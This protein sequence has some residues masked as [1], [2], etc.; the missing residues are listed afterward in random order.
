MIANGRLELEPPMILLLPPCPYWHTPSEAQAS[1]RAV[2]KLATSL[3]FAR[4][5]PS[6]VS[7]SLFHA[8]LATTPWVRLPTT[9]SVLQSSAADCKY[10]LNRDW[11]Q[12]VRAQIEP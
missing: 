3:G 4:K 9:V 12:S 2:W 6:A 7:I 5:R 1:T 11:S 8:S 10:S